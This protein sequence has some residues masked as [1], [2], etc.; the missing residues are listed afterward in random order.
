MSENEKIAR[1][2]LEFCSGIYDHEVEDGMWIKVFDYLSKNA[3]VLSF[4]R[5]DIHLLWTV[6]GGHLRRKIKNDELVLDVL[7][8]YLPPYEGPG[9]VVYRGECR[10]LYDEKKIGFSWTREQRVA[11]CFASGLN[12]IESGGVLLKAFASSEAIISAPNEHSSVQMQEYEYTCNPRLL[13]DI[14]VI[15][16]F[17]RQ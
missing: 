6:N 2:T 3:Q 1:L 4:D 5:N 9:H 7:L 11:R 14:E 12:A 10:F 17:E 16:L 8:K 13:E 15:D